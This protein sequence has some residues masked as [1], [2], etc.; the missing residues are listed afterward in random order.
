MGLPS[1]LLWADKNVGA[2]A[3]TDDGLYFSWGNVD[4]HAAGSGY[5]FSQGSYDDTPGKE[6][7]TNIDLNSDAAHVNLGESWRMPSRAEF[8]ELYNN[9]TYE[10]TSVNGVAGLLFTSSINGN[11]VFF[12]ASGY[13]SGTSQ[14]NHGTNGDYWSSTILS[15]LNAYLLSF[16]SSDVNPNNGNLRRLGF[17]VRAVRDP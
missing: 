11:S 15:E 13:Y 14:T 3:R 10:W 6:I 7:T 16:D 4:G 17:P 12:P 1:G 8:R 2:N 5:D 9:C